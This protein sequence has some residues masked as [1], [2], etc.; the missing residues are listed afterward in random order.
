M[1][2]VARI[3]RA[4]VDPGSTGTEPA[5]VAEA[6]AS[7]LAGLGQPTAA[8]R[9]MAAGVDLG[10]LPG[11]QSCNVPWV[12]AGSA[13]E[14]VF[15]EE[16]NPIPLA[17]MT[18]SNLAVTPRF[19]SVAMAASRLLFKSSNAEAIFGFMLRQA[20]ARGLDKAL[21]STAAPSASTPAGLL[22][23]VT[24]LANTT[25][26]MAADLATLMAA[27]ISAGG[28]QNILY[29]TSPGR[30]QAM[31][32]ASRVE[33]PIVGSLALSDD[34]LV[35]ID[36]SAFFYSISEP[37]IRTTIEAVLS[38]RD[39]PKP[40]VSGTGVLG[41]PERSLFQTDCV[42]LAIETYLGWVVPPGL[43]QL[44]TSPQW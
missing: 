41:G 34:Q 14:L 25:G 42:A 26:S 31:R 33:L 43:T 10:L 8:S 37:S 30:A 1:P 7:F 4:A 36:A 3:T 29:A 17:D 39:D 20:A 28:G 11:A 32:I 18:A 23:G 13:P 12:T 9:L 27:I 40:L 19:A 38:M 24:P 2:R 21:L 5:I 22:Y 44:I 35:A 15:I 16:G 6:F